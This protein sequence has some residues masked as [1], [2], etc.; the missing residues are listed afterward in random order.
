MDISIALY[1]LRAVPFRI[2]HNEDGMGRL[3]RQV[4]GKYYS[5]RWF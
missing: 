5:I 3:K 4:R 1:C 2:A